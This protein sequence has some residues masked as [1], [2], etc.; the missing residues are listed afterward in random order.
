MHHPSSR[1]RAR[2]SGQKAAPCARRAAALAG[3]WAAGPFTRGAAALAVDPDGERAVAD[4]VALEAAL[5]RAGRCPWLPSGRLDLAATSSASLGLLAFAGRDQLSTSRRPRARL[6][7]T[8]SAVWCGVV[9][10]PAACRPSVSPP[11]PGSTSSG[12]PGRRRRSSRRQPA[13]SDRRPVPAS[14]GDA[15]DRA[16]VVIE[17]SVASSTARRAPS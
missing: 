2:A 4:R 8:P 16:D 14:A 13:G 1:S 5:D 15:A 6:P 12:S 7:R 17:C 11:V 9:A 3:G 10:A